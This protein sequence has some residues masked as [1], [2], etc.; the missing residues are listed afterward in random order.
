MPL[1]ECLPKHLAE[2]V[3]TAQVDDY[4]AG[5]DEVMSIYNGKSGDLLKDV[6]APYNIRLARKKFLRLI[7]QG[8]DIQWGKKL[9]HVASDGKTATAT[10]QD[11]TNASGNLL[12]GTE[13]AHSLVR[14]YLLGPEKAVLQQSPLVASVTMAKL[15]AEAAMKFKEKSR[16]QF[17]AFHPQGYFTWVG[18]HDAYGDSQPGDWTFMMIMSWIPSDANYDV[19]SL[20]GD[21]IL[22]DLKSRAEDFSDDNKFLWQSIPEGTRCWHNRLSSWTPTPWDNHNGTVTLVGDAAHPMTFR[23]L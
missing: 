23:K 9:A 17:I 14:E 12:I 3:E 15:P 4:R 8:V 13:G 5:E 22:R 16:R 18:I 20:Q 11:G 10:F 1:H 21:A 7:S 6:P 2:Q 19:S